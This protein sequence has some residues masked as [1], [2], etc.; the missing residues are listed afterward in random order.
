MIFHILAKVWLFV[1]IQ[2]NKN[3]LTSYFFAHNQR[4]LSRFGFHLFLQNLRCKLEQRLYNL[5]IVDHIMQYI[6]SILCQILKMKHFYTLLIVFSFFLVFWVVH[7]INKGVTSERISL[8]EWK[9]IVTTPNSLMV[10]WHYFSVLFLN[11]I[12]LGFNPGIS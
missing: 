6:E 7:A 12:I 11:I 10:V 4:F 9:E 2:N 8:G 1:S 3:L 5:G